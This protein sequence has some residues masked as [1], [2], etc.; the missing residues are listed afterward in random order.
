MDWKEDMEVTEGEELRRLI[1]P[2][3]AGGGGGID[4]SKV[5]VRRN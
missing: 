5:L 4:S 2:G 3:G 1:R